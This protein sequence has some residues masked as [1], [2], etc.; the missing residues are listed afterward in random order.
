MQKHTP[1]GLQSRLVTALNFDNENSAS[2]M[3]GRNMQS[4]KTDGQ[5]TSQVSDFIYLIMVM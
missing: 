4:V 2:E 5:V 3:G 1:T